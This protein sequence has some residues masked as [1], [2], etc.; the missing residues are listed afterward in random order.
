MK[1]PRDIK[2]SLEM[3]LI[4]KTGGEEGPE[5]CGGC[6]QVPLA[7]P[8]RLGWQAHR[9]LSVVLNIKKNF[10]FFFFLLLPG[11][12]FRNLCNR[13]AKSKEHSVHGQGQLPKPNSDYLLQEHFMTSSV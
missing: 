11:P 1:M 5:R 13:L 6:C 2:E 12:A 7:G 8:V 9:E 10:F 3:L 4:T